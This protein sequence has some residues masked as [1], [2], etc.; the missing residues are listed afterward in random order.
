VA[1]RTDF[2]SAK[3]ENTYR[4]ATSQGNNKPPS[5]PAFLQPL[6]ELAAKNGG[7]QRRR[8]PIAA[9]RN[10]GILS[11]G[12]STSTT[13]NKFETRALWSTI[14][15]F[16]AGGGAGMVIRFLFVSWAVFLLASQLVCGCATFLHWL[17]AG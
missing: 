13:M 3:A 1:Q 7:Y 14:R 9:S 16:S 4:Q 2:L 12:D 15:R 11:F 6:E 8:N 5:P 17:S 10:D